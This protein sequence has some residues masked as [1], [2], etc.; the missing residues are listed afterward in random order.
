MDEKDSDFST[1]L[2]PGGKLGILPIDARG[3]RQRSEM[4][5]ICAYAGRVLNFLN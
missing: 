1:C 4:K 3:R 2:F 5:I